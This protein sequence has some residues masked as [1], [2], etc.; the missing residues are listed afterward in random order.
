MDKYSKIPSTAR[1]IIINSEE[2]KIY[3]VK[4]CFDNITI[5]GNV[6]MEKV[7][8][9]S[10]I[11]YGVR[12]LVDR[13]RPLVSVC[14]N[15]KNLV[16][17][18]ETLLN[19]IEFQDYIGKIQLSAYTKSLIT[20]WLRS[21][22]K[23]VLNEDLSGIIEIV[24][25]NKNDISKILT[26]DKNPNEYFDIMVDGDIES[27]VYKVSGE[28]GILT[29]HLFLTIKNKIFKDPVKS[30]LKID[31]SG[32][33]SEYLYIK[34][35]DHKSKNILK[36]LISEHK[37]SFI[38]SGITPLAATRFVIGS[39]QETD[40]SWMTLKIWEEIILDLIFMN[41]NN[42]RLDNY[43]SKDYRDR[44]VL[45]PVKDKFSEGLQNIK[46]K[47]SKREKTEFE[48]GIEENIE[49]L[50]NKI[51]STTTTR[52]RDLFDLDKI[53]INKTQKSTDKILTKRIKECRFVYLPD[54]NFEDDTKF[55]DI[56]Y[57]LQ[58]YDEKILD[59]NSIV[60]LLTT[61]E[62]N[63]DEIYQIINKSRVAVNYNP[64]YFDYMSNYGNTILKRI[65]I[66]NKFIKDEI[67]RR[68]KLEECI[69]Q[70]EKAKKRNKSK[71]IAIKSTDLNEENENVGSKYIDNE[72]LKD[73]VVNTGKIKD[74]HKTS[75]NNFDDTIILNPS[76][77]E[78]NLNNSES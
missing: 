39:L 9:N 69:K 31:S 25:L 53:K 78:T 77:I 34:F 15:E 51:S 41:E 47:F 29:N 20:D 66:L 13:G 48:E 4:E 36:D 61:L 54:L 10:D 8:F 21:S 56:L 67:N 6:D 7:D 23:N 22:E 58:K 59:Y 37:K 33:L 62:N 73:N 52:I 35:D 3:D 1:I 60:P 50:K 18:V 30:E 24:E 74:E 17:L 42:I 16:N 75:D 32:K 14:T 38:K 11:F 57:S 65:D 76:E 46:D 63:M 12:N 40:C 45:E 19:K 64:E 44:S 70:E 55:L 72:V 5:E 68:I 43:T 27:L 28:K 49:E 2:D 26:V 71:D